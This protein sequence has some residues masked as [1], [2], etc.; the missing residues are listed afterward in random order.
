M[1]A[2]C[3]AVAVQQGTLCPR[4]WR[5]WA[6]GGRWLEGEGV[7][8]PA[9]AHCPE[10]IEWREEGTVP[11]ERGSRVQLPWQPVHEDGLDW[12]WASPHRPRLHPPL[13][14]PPPRKHHATARH[15]HGSHDTGVSSHNGETHCSGRTSARQ[16]ALALPATVSAS[17]S[18]PCSSTSGTARAA[19][20]GVT[21]MKLLRWSKLGLAGACEKA[22]THTSTQC[23]AWLVNTLRHT[24]DHSHRR[25]REEAS[26][27]LCTSYIPTTAGTSGATGG[28]A[29]ARAAAILWARG[30]ASG[31]TTAPALLVD[32][33]SCRI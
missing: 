24:W 3:Q 19:A 14:Q 18:M 15:N 1:W 8:L 5:D 33:S 4:G 17:G 6:R 16:P 2:R 30:T 20:L 32:T 26:R 31:F 25:W 9:P 7:W 27:Q 13:L 10:G 22:P 29:G 28:G 21:L 11:Q 23:H 12:A